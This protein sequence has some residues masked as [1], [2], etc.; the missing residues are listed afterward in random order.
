MEHP[1]WSEQTITEQIN[2]V[3]DEICADTQNKQ[4]TLLHYQLTVNYSRRHTIDDIVSG[5]DKPSGF[6][7]LILQ[8]A[9]NNKSPRKDDDRTIDFSAYTFG[10]SFAHCHQLDGEIR[11]ALNIVFEREREAAIVSTYEELRYLLETNGIYRLVK[12]SY[13]FRINWALANMRLLT[14]IP[15]QLHLQPLEEVQHIERSTANLST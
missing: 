1:N 10:L 9:F 14:S 7:D 6:I 11:A 8:P 5:K 3:V 2:H 12:T 15:H 13:G 4:L